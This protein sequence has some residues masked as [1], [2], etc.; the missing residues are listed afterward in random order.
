MSEALSSISSTGERKRKDTDGRKEQG[1]EGGPEER[2]Q[3]KRRNSNM[4]E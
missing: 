1:R 2:K 4:D 3:G